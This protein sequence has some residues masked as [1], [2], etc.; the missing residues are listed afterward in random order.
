M[1][2]TVF[3]GP[4]LAGNILNTNGTAVAKVGGSTG[5]QNVGFAIMGQAAAITQSATA[6]S[7]TIVIP[8]GSI[9]TDVI[10]NITAGWTNSATLSIGTSATSTELVS[11]IANANISSSAQYTVTGGTMAAW[12]NVSATQDVQVYVKS[13]AAPSGTTGAAVLIV[14]YLQGYNTFTRGTT[15]TAYTA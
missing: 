14:C 6:A 2:T 1:S 13:S 11:S 4:V 3:T 12:N 7:T 15:N 5:L 9:I 8:A 10:L